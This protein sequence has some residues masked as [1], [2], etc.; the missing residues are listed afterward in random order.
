MSVLVSTAMTKQAADHPDFEGFFAAFASEVA[1]VVALSTGDVG[2]AEEV[3]QEAMVRA[4]ANWAR[5]CRM[6]RPDLWVIR[7]A[8]RLAIDAW[9]RR[10]REVRLR[11]ALHPAEVPDEI[12]GLWVR[13]GLRHLRP[14]DRLLI[15]LRHRDGLSIEEI[16]SHLGKSPH[17]MAAYLKRARQRLR[18]LMSDGD[19]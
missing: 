10:A 16:A 7:V 11:E 5:V 19:R 18:A 8:T 4:H 17:T 6:D 1:A 15:I 2:L 13:W 9:R 3:T 12:L 14:E